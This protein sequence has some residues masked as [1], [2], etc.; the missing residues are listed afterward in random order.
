MTSEL[1]PIKQNTKPASMHSIPKPTHDI[2]MDMMLGSV[3]GSDSI[4]SVDGVNR[5]DRVDRVAMVDTSS[6]LP[7]TTASSYESIN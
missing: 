3:D 1:F 5:G 2:H 7:M 6:L 4:D